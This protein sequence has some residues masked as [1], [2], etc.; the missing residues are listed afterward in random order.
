MNALILWPVK[1]LCVISFTTKHT[2][3]LEEFPSIN[4][5]S[6]QCCF[7]FILQIYHKQQIILKRVHKEENRRV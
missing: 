4:V 7:V 1:L 3:L 2:L 6:H 5:Q